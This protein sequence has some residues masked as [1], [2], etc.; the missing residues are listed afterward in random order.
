MKYISGMFAAV[1]CAIVFPSAVYAQE[2][3]GE[4]SVEIGSYRLEMPAQGKPRGVYVFFHGHRGSAEAQMQHRELV[5]TAHRLGLAFAA[6]DGSNNT[7]S[8]PGAPSQARDEKRFVAEVLDSLES[9]FGFTRERILIGGFSSGASMAWYALCQ[10]GGRIAGAV[11]FSGVFWTPLPTAQ[12]CAEPIPP[13]VHFHGRADTVFPLAGRSIRDRW[14]QGDTFKSMALIRE[15]AICKTELEKQIGGLA[16]EATSCAR[17]DIVL[18][19]HAGE[20]EISAAHLEAGLRA[21]VDTWR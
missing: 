12:E 14:R 13:L 21:I 15:R 1:L 19:L 6:P 4:C 16:C 18:C 11:T 10:H 8:F 5:E 2:C 7:W 9:R 20:H 17:G 3:G